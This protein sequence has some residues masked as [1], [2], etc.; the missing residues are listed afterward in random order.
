VPANPIP[1]CYLCVGKDC[2]R[3]AG[4]AELRSALGQLG[5]VRKVKCQDLC[6]GPVAGIEVGGRV[7][8]FEGIKKS[9]HREAVLAL[10]TGATTKV[11]SELKGHRVG[12]RSGKVKR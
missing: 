9:R 7:E 4:Y 5:K 8:W 6:E 2:R 10:A 12:K 11:P 3:D 1:Q